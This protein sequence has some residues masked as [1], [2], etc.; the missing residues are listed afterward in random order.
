MRTARPAISGIQLASTGKFEC[1]NFSNFRLCHAIFS[2]CG[3]SSSIVSFKTVLE[4]ILILLIRKTAALSKCNSVF[5]SVKIGTLELRKSNILAPKRDG[6]GVILDSVIWLA[7]AVHIIQISGSNLLRTQS[8]TI[9]TVSQVLGSIIS[10]F[11]GVMFGPLYFRHL[12]R[13]KS[14]ALTQ[15]NGNF[16]SP[17]GLSVE[18]KQELSWWVNS[19]SNTYNVVSHG[20]PEV[21]LTTDSSLIGWGCMF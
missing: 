17:M 15:A 12:E 1:G 11:P 6:D 10:T 13:D 21:T 20:E 16:V 9:R 4:Y 3:I 5:F 14:L 19:A 2:I 8:P 7:C 18:A